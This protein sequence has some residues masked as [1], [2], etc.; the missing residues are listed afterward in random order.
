MV[1]GWKPV[2]IPDEL[3]ERA[4]EYYEENKKELKLKQGIRSLTAFI[5]HCI[6]EY[7]KSE[8]II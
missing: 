8:E 2:V 7:M 3:F 4:Q 6:R 1:D 5:G